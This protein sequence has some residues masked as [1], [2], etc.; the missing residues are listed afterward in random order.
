MPIQRSRAALAVLAKIAAVVPDELRSVMDD[1]AVGTPSA[2]GI[3]AG[4]HV[5]LARLCRWS[6]EGRKLMIQYLDETGR[7]SERT[8]W[9]FLVG[10]VTGVQ[11][12]M[13]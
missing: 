6:Q 7:A 11:T 13:A 10:Y 1:P 5:D 9:P 12:V 8:V 4:A 3:R 2:R